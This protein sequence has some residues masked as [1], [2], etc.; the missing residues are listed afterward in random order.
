MKCSH[1]HDH[2]GFEQTLDVVGD[3]WTMELLHHLVQGRNRFGVLHR[4]LKGI[5]PKTLSF[6]LRQLE[7]KGIITRTVFP[8]VPPRVEYYLTTRGR[9]LQ[10][11]IEKMDDWGKDA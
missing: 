1:E 10:Q 2:R 9:S 7:A 3:K 5:S 6:R 8:E 11:V 4:T